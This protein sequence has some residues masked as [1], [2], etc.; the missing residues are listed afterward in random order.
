[1]RSISSLITFNYYHVKIFNNCTIH[2]YCINSKFVLQIQIG[3]NTNQIP[4]V[5]ILKQNRIHAIIAGMK[6]TTIL[7]NFATVRNLN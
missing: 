2:I 1:M 3:N 4:L 5:V 7:L 6:R